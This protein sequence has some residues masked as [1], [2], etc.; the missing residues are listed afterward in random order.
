MVKLSALRTVSLDT[1]VFIYHIQESPEYLITTAIFDRIEKGV[2]KG[3]T[4]SISLLEVLVKPFK[5]GDQALA[6]K[7]ED[8]LTAFPNLQV[9]SVDADLAREAAYLRAKYDLLAPDAIV[10]A[11]ALGKDA[12]VTNDE[13][14]KTVKEIKAV[15]LNELEP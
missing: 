15:L 2:L 7:Y 12:L 14:F 5:A 1:N 9:L 3:Y 10:A 8:T 4:T 6:K 13:T 11:S